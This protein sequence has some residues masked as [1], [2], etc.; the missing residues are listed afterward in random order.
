M[1]GYALCYPIRKEIDVSLAVYWAAAARRPEA[2]ERGQARWGVLARRVQDQ[3]W[4]A[5]IAVDNSVEENED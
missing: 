5:Y 4:A 1:N 3:G 2:L